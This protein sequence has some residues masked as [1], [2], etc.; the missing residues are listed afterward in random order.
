MEILLVHDWLEK[1]LLFDDLFPLKW[2]LILSEN[3]SRLINSL[4]IQL[5]PLIIKSLL[6]LFLLFCQLLYFPLLFV[7]CYL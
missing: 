5:F 1:L 3:L 6:L 7:I 2:S 4:L